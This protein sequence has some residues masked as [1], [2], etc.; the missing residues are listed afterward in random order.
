LCAPRDGPGVLAAI[1]LVPVRPGGSFARRFARRP[2][3]DG[4]NVGIPKYEAGGIDRRSERRISEP[5][6][7]PSPQ[8]KPVEPQRRR[9]ERREKP[10]VLRCI[11]PRPGFIVA[12]VRSVRRMSRA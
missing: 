5:P 12:S 2:Q 4:S 8:L 9:H 11:E 3:D 6:K 1:G 10:L 7:K